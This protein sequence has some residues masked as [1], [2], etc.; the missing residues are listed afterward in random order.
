[1]TFLKFK[2]FRKNTEKSDAAGNPVLE[3]IQGIR[4]LL[5][6]QSVLMEE[7][8][9][10]QEAAAAA[11]SGRSIDSLTEL[12]DSVFYLQ[13]AFRHPGF[14][15]REH[16][17]VLGMVMKRLEL[18]AA[19]LG[20]EIILDEGI[21]FDPKMHEAV[22]NRSPG[23]NALQVTEVVQPGYIQNGKVIRP[24]RVIVDAP[25]DEPLISEGTAS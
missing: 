22:E 25:E 4:K 18:F 9:R 17:Q 19:S 24:A 11:K 2:W 16:A 1:M 14:M 13:R 15:S 5:R 7:V 8:R 20:I 10:E 12:C 21:I 6:K 23:S 3:E